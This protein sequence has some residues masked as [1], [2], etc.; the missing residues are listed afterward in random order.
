MLAFNASRFVWLDISAIISVTVW[1]CCADS[2]VSLDCSLTFSISSPFFLLM[3][4]SSDIMSSADALHSC[5]LSALA[6]SASTFSEIIAISSPIASIFSFISVVC[7]ACVTVLSAIVCTESC[8]ISKDFSISWK[9]SLKSE[10]TDFS[11]SVAPIIPLITVAKD[12][13][14]LYTE[15]RISPISSS[16][17]IIF[18]AFSSTFV[19]LCLSVTLP[20]TIIKNC[21]SID[22]TTK[23]TTPKIATLTAMIRIAATSVLMNPL[24]RSSNTAT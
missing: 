12:R 11:S 14:E 3:E 18:F 9:I 5:I 21:V 20:C 2:L 10:D 13:I 19:V 22:F 1:I 16:R 24:L 4:I 17:S 8:V 23:K 15:R 7:D 6:F